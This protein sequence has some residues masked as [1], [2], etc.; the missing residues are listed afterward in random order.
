MDAGAEEWDGGAYDLYGVP[1]QGED[2]SLDPPPEALYSAPG[3]QIDQDAGSP[4]DPDP[5]PDPSDP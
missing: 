5:D 2:A 3:F 4:P 1:F